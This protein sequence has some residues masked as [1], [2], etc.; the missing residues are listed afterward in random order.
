MNGDGILSND[1]MFIPS[2]FG[3][4]EVIFLGD[5]AAN[6]RPAETKFWEIV[7]GN[8]GLQKYAGG[9]TERNSSFAPWAH[10][11]DV[12]FAQELPGFWN[13]HK[14]IIALDILN[15]GNLLNKKWGHIDEVAFAG[16]GG[17]PRSFVN[18]VGIDPASGKYIYSVRDPDN[19][20][21]R[22]ARG[23]SQWAI[24]LTLRYEF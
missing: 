13:T 20:V 22:Q 1:L 2:A 4:G 5:T 9:V 12:R 17:T 24:Q 19:L 3:S 14:S 6:G 23:E 10:S 18:F 7:Q 11:V 16:Q 8:Y 15:F 21:T